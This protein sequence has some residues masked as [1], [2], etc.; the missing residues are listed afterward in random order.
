MISLKAFKYRLYPNQEQQEKLAVQ[1]GHSRFVYNN[2]LNARKE[3]YKQTGK[4]LSYSATTKALP[5]MK[6]TLEWLKQADS[7]VLQQKLKDLDRAYTNFFQGR[8]AYPRFK[9]KYDNQSIRYPQRFKFVENRIYLPKVGSV[10]IVLHR[11]IEGVAKNVTI[12]KT[13]S[14]KY[15]ASVQCEVQIFFSTTIFPLS[16]WIL[17][18][19]MLQFFISIWNLFLPVFIVYWR[20]KL[21]RRET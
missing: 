19:K 7:Q 13:K 10:K 17:V 2:A 6:K 9:S 18:S 20:T 5:G 11:D 8:A 21:N 14:G 15:F 16:E 3:H 4:G 1:F 12:S